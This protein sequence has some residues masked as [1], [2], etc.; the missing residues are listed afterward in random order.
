MLGDRLSI[1][2]RGSGCRSGRSS[3]LADA[4]R[5]RSGGCESYGSEVPHH[6][7]AGSMGRQREP[8]AFFVFTTPSSS[9]LMPSNQRAA[10]A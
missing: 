8:I 6:F 9:A 7:A 2:R 4:I 1:A 3:A 5:S 10:R